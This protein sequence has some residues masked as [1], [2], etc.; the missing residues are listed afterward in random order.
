M[1]NLQLAL[2]ALQSGNLPQADL[3]LT[4]LYAEGPNDPD[5]LQLLGLVRRRQG[6]TLDAIACFRKSLAV[7]EAQPHVY[8]NLGLTLVANQQRDEAEQ[9]YRR[10]LDLNPIYADAA[11]NLA[12][13]L[14]QRGQWDG[15]KSLLE[16]VIA[17]QPQSGRAFEALGIALRELGEPLPGLS[18]AQKAVE[19]SPQSHTAFHNLGQ[20]FSEVANYESAA[21]AYSRALKLQ[22]HS[23][24]SWIGLGHAYRG[25]GRAE[26]AKLSYQRAVSTSPGNADAHRLFNEMVW[27][28]GDVN[29]YLQSYK[30]TLQQR[31]N[32]HKLRLAYANDLL[33]VMQHDAAK[34]E[35]SLALQSAPDDGEVL[36]AMARVNSREGD[37]ETAAVYHKRAIEAL[38]ADSTLVCHFAETLLRAKVHD[39]AYEI[40]RQARQRFPI[41]QGILAFHSI[42]QRLVGDEEHCRLSDYAGIVKVLNLEPPVGYP[43]IETFCKDLKTCLDALHTTKAHPTDQTVRGGTQTF[44]SLFANQAPILQLFKVQLNKAVRS[45]ICQLPGDVSHPFFS[46]AKQDFDYSGSWSVKLSSGGFHTN[47]IHPK[48]WISSAFYV[49]VPDEVSADGTQDGWLKFG[50]TNLELGDREVIQRIVQ[51]KPG[52]LAL[53]PS[54]FWHGTV[55]FSSTTPRITI[56]FD[57]VPK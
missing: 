55:P 14:S 45:Y 40:T 7:N 42:A 36:D 24:S 4:R 37:F 50:E 46:R 51:P 57:V 48:G 6:N 26:D 39:T 10:A 12:L 29:G 53:F 13:L 30:I 33:K 8:N 19:L 11:Y 17:W 3:L 25:L 31:T 15:A 21:A 41:E 2:S 54:Y 5:V 18:A 28:T 44:R 9:S 27:Q 56:S 20:A 35:L 32:D 34:I 16:K 22:P 47:H 52:S 38:P 49:A 1:Q 43:D 23:D